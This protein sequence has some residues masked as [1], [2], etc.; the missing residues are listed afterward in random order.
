MKFSLRFLIIMIKIINNKVKSL[1]FNKIDK[2]Q[3]FLTFKI[4]IVLIYLN[5]MFLN[6]NK[7]INNFKSKI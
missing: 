6:S 2:Q 1:R 5:L 3:I 4:Q 7:N